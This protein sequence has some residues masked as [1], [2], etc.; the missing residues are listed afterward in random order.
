MAPKTQK[1]NQKEAAAKTQQSK[2]NEVN[3]GKKI[4]SLV[5]EATTPIRAGRIAS[6]M[7]DVATPTRTRS[8]SSLLG[9]DKPLPA[10]FTEMSNILYV[11]NWLVK[12]PHILELANQMLTANNTSSN[13]NM[14]VNSLHGNDNLLGMNKAHLRNEESKCLFLR[15]RNPSSSDLNN[16]ILAVLGYKPCSE[17]A[18]DYGKIV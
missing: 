7:P 5:P 16:F 9:G 17:M 3:R 10:S 2:C 14:V 8:S 15:I 13:T 11:C 1:L 6:L 4:S 12:R 18:K